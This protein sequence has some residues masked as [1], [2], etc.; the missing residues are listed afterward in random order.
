MEENVQFG[1]D[2]SQHIGFMWPKQVF[3]YLNH[4]QH[5]KMK[6]F[7]ANCS[8]YVEIKPNFSLGGHLLKKKSHPAKSTRFQPDSWHFLRFITCLVFASL[9]LSFLQFSA[10]LQMNREYFL[11]H[12]LGKTSEFCC[13]QAVGIIIKEGY[14]HIYIFK[15]IIMHRSQ[16]HNLSF[17]NF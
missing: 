6:R 5:F 2:L 11:P 15:G 16:I 3:K 10:Q 8:F 1:Q 13:K 14:A 4:F 12:N 17:G 9:Y 7:Q